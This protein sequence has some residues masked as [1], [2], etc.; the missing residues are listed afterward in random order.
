MHQLS[1]WTGFR[2]EN[3][4]QSSFWTFRKLLLTIPNMIRLTAFHGH[5]LE[6]ALGFERE[7]EAM[8]AYV[9][10]LCCKLQLRVVQ[11]MTEKI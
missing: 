3:T 8:T 7:G 2:G 10:V 9:T 11:F 6:I 4:Q 5:C 1:S